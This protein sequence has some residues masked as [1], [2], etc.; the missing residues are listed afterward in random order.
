MQ[1][2]MHRRII[3]QIQTKRFGVGVEAVWSAPTST[4]TPGS[5]PRLR[6][7]PTPTPTPAPTP[8]PCL[9][10]I[11]VSSIISAFY[12]AKRRSWMSSGSQKVSKSFSALLSC[13]IKVFMDYFNEMLVIDSALPVS[14]M[15]NF[16]RLTR[17]WNTYINELVSEIF[18][19][20]VAFG[21]ANKKIQALV[22]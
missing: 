4:P 12:S 9:E 1:I 6:S 7:T 15:T 19:I 16:N 3:S 21:H 5:F 22:H 13:M 17:L 10:V 20:R 18:L 8:H 14:S 2:P 11:M